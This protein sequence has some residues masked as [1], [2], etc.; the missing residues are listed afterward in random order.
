MAYK[1][2]DTA[3]I[4]NE[5]GEKVLIADELQYVDSITISSTTNTLPPTYITDY[6]PVVSPVQGSTSGYSSGGIAVS[7]THLRAHE[8]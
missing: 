3:I 8:T 6:F 1:I 2:S 7:Y 5:G 4:V